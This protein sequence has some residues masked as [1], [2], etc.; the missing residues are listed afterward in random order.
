[1]DFV[2]ANNSAG[3]KTDVKVSYPDMETVNRGLPDWHKN[4]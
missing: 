3:R 1:M 2:F 4:L